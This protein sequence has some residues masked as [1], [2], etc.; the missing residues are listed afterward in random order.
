M[1]K[2]A[3]MFSSA[4]IIAILVPALPA[5][6]DRGEAKRYSVTITNVT[7]GQIITPPVLFSHSKDFHLFKLGMKASNEL[8]TQAETGDPM[9]LAGLL[10]VFSNP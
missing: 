7:G 5:L 6:A 8:A 4:L 9:A 1:K 2:R 3:K 10:A